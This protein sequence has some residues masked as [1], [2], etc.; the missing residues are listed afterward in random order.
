MATFANTKAGYTHHAVSGKLHYPSQLGCIWS[1]NFTNMKITSDRFP[2]EIC[3][4]FVRLCSN[5]LHRQ[6]HNRQSDLLAAKA[7]GILCDSTVPSMYLS[8]HAQLDCFLDQPR[9][10]WRQADCRH[11][12]HS[13]HRLLVGLCQCYAAQGLNYEYI[14]IKNL[15]VTIWINLELLLLTIEFS[16]IVIKRHTYFNFPTQMVSK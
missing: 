11:H 3:T 2:K 12:V 16:C 13:H 4:W 6:L 15:D 9:E 5:C 14:N 10:R 1:S 7:C 8:G